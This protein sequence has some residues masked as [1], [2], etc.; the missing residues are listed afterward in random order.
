MEYRGELYEV[1][2]CENEYMIHPS[3][4]G[5]LPLWK[6]SSPFDFSMKVTLDNYKITLDQMWVDADCMMPVIN[7][8]AP[9]VQFEEKQS[10]GVTYEDL[11]VQILYTG[12]ILVANTLVNDYDMEVPEGEKYPCFCYK[13]VYEYVFE[14][15]ILITT[16]DHSRAMLRI[17]KNLDLGYRYLNK[18]RDRRC[19][20]QFIK[21]SL[22]GD[23]KLKK[24]K[25]KKELYLAQ[26]RSLYKERPDVKV[27]MKL[28]K[29]K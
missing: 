18:K 29:L 11:D 13:V 4:F 26:M 6:D 23:Y 21:T 15:G 10:Q 5:I 12:S 19:I 7:G 22:V 14:N 9:K 8:V 27:E 16:I 20:E 3:V 17:R 2:K 28:N 1:L 24:N 25:K